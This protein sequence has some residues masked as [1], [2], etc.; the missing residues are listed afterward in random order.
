MQST[1]HR[2][3]NT[4]LAGDLLT[5]Y[6]TKFPLLTS[7]VACGMVVFS[8][9]PDKIEMIGLKHRGISHSLILY[10]ILGWIC[11]QLP[12]LIEA[13]LI[14]IPYIGCGL[15][16]GCLGHILADMFSKNGI[17]V[18]TKKIRFNLYST[19]NLSEQIFLFS[20]VLLNCLLIYWFLFTK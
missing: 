9:F 12:T 6:Y 1:S 13:Q 11:L 17:V 4:V 8:S 16:C 20:F 15:V 7:V 19:G 14:W 5:I 3:F 18:L 10:L 2:I